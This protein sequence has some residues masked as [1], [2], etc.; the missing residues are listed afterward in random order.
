MSRLQKK[1]W[2]AAALLA[3]LAA[4]GGARATGKV[5]VHFIEPQKYADAGRFTVDRERTMSALGEFMESL[6]KELPDGQLLTLDVLDIDLAGTIEPLRHNDI[7]IIRDRADWP[8]MTLRYTLQAGDTP[9]AATLKSGTDD[10]SDIHYMQSLRGADTLDGSFGY[11][12][13]MVRQ[14]FRKTVLVH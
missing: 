12:K 11:E 2:A 10:L 8:R 9:G 4:S 7:R 13:R 5:E 6:G 1:S 3:L 14:W